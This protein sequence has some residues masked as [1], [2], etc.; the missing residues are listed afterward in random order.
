M[1]TK[2]YKIC[3]LMGVYNGADYIEAQLDSILAQHHTN[4]K[5]LIRDDGSQ[6]RSIKILE[7]YAGRDTRITLVHDNFGNKGVLGNFS[8]LME[9]ALQVSSEY[10]AFSDQDD[11]WCPEKLSS[12]LELMCQAEVTCQENP[13]LVHSDLEVVT[14]SL[15]SISPSLMKYQG[16]GHQT[17][18]PLKVLLVQN[19]VT[20]CT[21]MINRKLLEIALPVPKEALMHDWWIALCA[22]AFGQIRFINKPLVRYR[23]HGNNAVGAKAVFQFLNPLKTNWYDVWLSGKLH[24]AQSISQARSLSQRIL[25]YDLSNCYLPLVKAYSSIVNLSPVNRLAELNRLGIRPQTRF[26]QLLAISRILFL[27]RK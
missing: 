5:L 26:R 12:Q 9:K 17:S 24:L 1:E 7:K 11:I 2:Y 8:L 3:V 23:Q 16:I 10:F 18:D 22:T 20:G 14:A 15:G 4:W 19:F 21:V 27:S 25:E 13:I 6:D